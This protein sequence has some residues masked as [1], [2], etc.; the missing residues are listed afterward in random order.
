MLKIITKR[1]ERE[2]EALREEGRAQQ[3]REDIEYDGERIHERKYVD[4]G[5]PNLLRM[6]Y[7]IPGD[8]IV[9]TDGPRSFYRGE[10]V[11]HVWNEDQAEREGYKVRTGERWLVTE[12]VPRG[13]RSGYAMK[14]DQWVLVERKPSRE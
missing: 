2:E 3:R 8:Y 11:L 10:K 6:D 12:G 13:G 14:P 9:Y 4:P 1:D 5:K 7:L